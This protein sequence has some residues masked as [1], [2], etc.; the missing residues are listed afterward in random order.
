MTV[1]KQFAQDGA[2]LDECM[3][4]LLEVLAELLQE[5]PDQPTAEAVNQGDCGA[6]AAL[7][8]GDARAIHVV[9]TSQEK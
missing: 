7:H 9:A 4:P 1:N 8:S 2:P 5:A 6:I 3:E